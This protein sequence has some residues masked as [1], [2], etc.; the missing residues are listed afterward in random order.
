MAK[1]SKDV[2]RLLTLLA[3]LNRRRGARIDQAAAELGLSRRTL[4]AELD[5]L[6]MCGA[7]PFGPNDL[8]MAAVDEEG[9][10]D[11]AYADQF[12]APLRLTPA[13][14]M[15]LRMALMPL[16]ERSDQAFARMAAGL[17]E[18]LERA[19]LPQDR[20]SYDRISRSMAA[21]SRDRDASGTLEAL[22]RARD[23]KRAVE[24]VYYSG[25][26]GQAKRRVV[27]PYGFVQSGGSW[28]LAGFCRLSGERRIFKVSRIKE[29]KLTGEAYRI[30]ADFDVAEYTKG[31]LF[32][33]SGAE[34]EVRI[35][36][37][38]AVARWILERNEGARRLKD[39]SAELAIK[40]G[41]FA[42]IAR[43]VLQYGREARILEP[44]EARAEVRKILDRRRK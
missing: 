35:R 33:P 42:W 24:M 37:S 12:R 27:E 18:K 14:A 21:A 2:Q 19:L 6:S 23:G 4:L 22:R 20:R 39:G 13:E 40:A 1:T 17:A 32:K 15:T 41:S 28:Y 44:P 29:L 30:P 25:S 10:L 8:F 7:P 5:R 36:F 9:R 31:G 43:W 3:F 26:T 34:K 16:M 11:I 38:P